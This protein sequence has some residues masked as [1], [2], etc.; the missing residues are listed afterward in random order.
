MSTADAY[1]G[2]PEIYSHYIS[3]APLPGDALGPNVVH[4]IT[5]RVKPE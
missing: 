5:F 2:E 1:A 4:D 3:D